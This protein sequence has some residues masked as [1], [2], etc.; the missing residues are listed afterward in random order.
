M[1]ISF[2]FREKSATS[3]PEMVNVN[4]SSASSSTINTVDPCGLAARK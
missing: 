2:L 1:F 4:M 3:A